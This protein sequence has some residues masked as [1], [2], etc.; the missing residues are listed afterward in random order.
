MIT[1]KIASALSNVGQLKVDARMFSDISYCLEGADAQCHR[2]V[3][4]RCLGEVRVKPY[5]TVF[6]NNVLFYESDAE[7]F[8]GDVVEMS[9]AIAGG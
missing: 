9:L 3:F 7:L 6:I 2:A 8:D 4:Y 5:V 1:L